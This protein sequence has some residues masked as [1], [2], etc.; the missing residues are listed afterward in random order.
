M[1]STFEY[2]LE[3]SIHVSITFRICAHTTPAI[4]SWIIKNTLHLIWVF[5]SWSFWWMLSTTQT[6]YSIL[7]CC[8]RIASAFRR[9]TITSSSICLYFYQKIPK[10]CSLTLTISIKLS[11]VLWLLLMSPLVPNLSYYGSTLGP[12]LK[13]SCKKLP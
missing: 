2:L 6:N 3:M 13:N 5:T 8:L 1:S 11:K 4:Y 9:Y 7:P 12:I 10:M